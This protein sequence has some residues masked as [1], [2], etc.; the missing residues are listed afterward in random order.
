MRHRTPIIA[1]NWK[2]FKSPTEGAALAQEIMAGLTELPMSEVVVCPPLVSLQS[3]YE[4]LRGTPIGLGAQDIHWEDSGA[5]TGEVSAPMLAGW[6]THVIIGH[7]ERRTYFGESDKQ[8]KLKVAAALQHGL[9]PIICVGENLAENESGITSAVVERQVRA[10]Y[11]DVT[12][13]QAIT[14]VIA[15]EPVWAIGTGMAS[16]CAGANAVCGINVRGVLTDI[17][18]ESVAQ[19]VRVQYGGSVK[20]ANIA[21]FIIQPDIDGALVGGASL[22]ADDFLA[23]VE[24]AV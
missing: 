22:D 24:N 18:G 8:V 20:P 19:S 21:D 16:T 5:Y 9:I 3:V 15:Y 11:T 10:A 23:I 6:C 17:F 4:V 14:T 1:G 12:A 13:E 2:M 7:S